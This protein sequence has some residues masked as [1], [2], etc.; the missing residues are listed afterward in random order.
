MK[1]NM[2]GFDWVEVIA[3]LPSFAAR[4]TDAQRGEGVFDQS[5]AALRQFN[6]APHFF[7]TFSREVPL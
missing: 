7:P 3:S 1:R 5:I 4:Q 2:S 6:D